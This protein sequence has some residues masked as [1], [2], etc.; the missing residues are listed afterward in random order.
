MEKKLQNKNSEQIE[1]IIS[2]SV[3]AIIINYDDEFFSLEHW[4]IARRKH[5]IVNLQSRDENKKI[6]LLPI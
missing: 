3:W 6:L 5:F 2:H 4:I 1:F